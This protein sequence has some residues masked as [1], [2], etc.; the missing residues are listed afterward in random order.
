MPIEGGGFDSLENIICNE[1][2]FTLSVRSDRLTQ[3]GRPISGDYILSAS[4]G[5][6]GNGRWTIST[7]VRWQQFPEGVLD[8]KEAQDSA[9]ENYVAE[10]GVL[11]TGTAAPDAQLI[12]LNDEAKVRL[13]DLRGKIVFLEFWAT[14]CGPCQEPLSN[15]QTLRQKHPDWKDRVAVITL[16]IDDELKQA[17]DHLQKHGWTNT[18]SVWAGPGGWRSEPA[19][20]FRL[21]MVPTAYV[22]NREG[23]VAWAGSPREILDIGTMLDGM[24]RSQSN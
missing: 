12:G 17:R 5:R 4:R 20:S 23:K 7:P 24:L 13:A 22:L 15:L 3:S 2:R 14:W 10:H 21:S 11:P 16:S 18:I 8:A 1:L 19:K 9:F 6:R